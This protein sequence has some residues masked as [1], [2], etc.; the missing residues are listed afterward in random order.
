[1][2]DSV[3]EV[4]GYYVL[5]TING[6]YGILPWVVETE[7]FQNYI[8]FV[9]I[10]SSLGDHYNV[11]FIEEFNE[12]ELC[13]NLSVVVSRNISVGEELLSDYCL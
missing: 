2:I 1:M 8:F 6:K 9:A 11:K 7:S 4:C 5:N 10:N 13:V 12:N 3:E